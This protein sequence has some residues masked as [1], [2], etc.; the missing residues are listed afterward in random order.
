M[1]VR[2]KALVVALVC[3]VW[4]MWSVWSVWSVPS[5]VWSNAIQKG[6]AQWE[7]SRDQKLPSCRVIEALLAGS[8]FP[9][10]SSQ[11]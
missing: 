9:I 5:V 2:R 4:S 1:L 10:N 7:A 3:T 6:T 8:I 11:L